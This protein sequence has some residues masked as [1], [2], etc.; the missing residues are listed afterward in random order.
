MAKQLT[1]RELR[2][3]YR[4]RFEREPVHEQAHHG[5]GW[6]FWT[7]LST[8]FVLAFLFVVAVEFVLPM[9]QPEGIVIQPLS[10]RTPLPTAVLPQS[11]AQQQYQQL[12]AAPPAQQQVAPVQSM[13][14]AQPPVAA[15][16]VVEQ[17]QPVAAPQPAPVEAPAPLPE[18][19]DPAFDASFAIQSDAANN[20]FVGCLPGRDC[21]PSYSQP[22]ALPEPGETGFKE[23]FH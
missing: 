19:A 14:Q 12:P 17:P 1:N 15:P 13:P 9:V 21:N 10:M 22:T 23:S 8:L 5:A 4:E 7:I 3:L 2:R 16:A 11:P 20:P 18:P 6:W